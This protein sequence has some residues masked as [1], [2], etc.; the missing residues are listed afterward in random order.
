MAEHIE[1]AVAPYFQ[2]EKIPKGFR[3]FGREN[4]RNWEAP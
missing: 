2:A 3:D 1:S 4:W